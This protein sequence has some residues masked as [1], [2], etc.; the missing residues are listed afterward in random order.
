MFKKLLL[1]FFAFMMLTFSF[2]PLAYAQAEPGKWYNQSFQ[3]WITKVDDSP[4]SE[5][6]GE[7]YTAAQ[8]QWVIYGLFFFRY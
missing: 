2:V 8:V 3:E 7:R 4:E 6:F 5:I 1:S